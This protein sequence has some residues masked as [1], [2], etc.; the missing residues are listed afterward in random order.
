MNS[1]D[2]TS[3]CPS[4]HVRALGKFKP[5]NLTVEEK[6]KASAL[7]EIESIKSSL[8]RAK[9][10]T[11]P[12]DRNEALIKFTKTKYLDSSLQIK[13]AKAISDNQRYRP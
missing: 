1:S 5:E 3:Y 10:L 12:S 7:F 8:Q 2:Y 13:A 6:A 9:A 11:C 4:M